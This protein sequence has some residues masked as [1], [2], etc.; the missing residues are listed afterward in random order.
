MLF[1]YVPSFFKKGDT[2][3]GGTLSKEMRYEENC[4]IKLLIE[5]EKGVRVNLLPHHQH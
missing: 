4:K 3:Q 1:F 2:I 5:I